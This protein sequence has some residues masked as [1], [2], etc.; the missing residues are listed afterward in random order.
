MRGPF[1]ID[2]GDGEGDVDK[3]IA[4]HLELR[5]REFMA[6][7]MTPEAARAAALEA[8]GDRPAIEAQV[9][10]IHR[11]TRSD[12]RRREWFGELR[13]D[14]RV[15]VRML[16]RSPGFAIA[17]LL[18]L[19]LGIGANTAIFSVLR[20]V[21]LR[22]LP[23]PAPAELVQVWAD[24]TA[25]GRAEPEW[26]TPPDFVDQQRDNRTFAAM[27][28]Y[29]GWGPDLTGIGDPVSLNGL[30]VSGDYFAIL[31]ATAA[32]G[33]L[34]VPGDDVPGAPPVVVLSHGLWQ[35]RFG[36]DPGVVGRTITLSGAPWTVVGV[37]SPGFRAPI[38]G[39]APELFRGLPLSAT[40]PCGRG[41]VVLRAIGRLRPG[42]TVASAQADLATIAARLARE[43]PRS[44]DKVGAWL[45]PLHEQLTG[46][47]RPALVTLA[48]AVGLVLL[49]GCVNLANLLLVRTAGRTRELGVRAALGAGR[50]RIARQLLGENG[51]LAILGG[52]LGLGLGIVTSRLLAARVPDSLRGVQDVRIDGWV[53]AFAVVLTAMS[54]LIFGL[55]P[56]LGAARS[57]LGSAARNPTLSPGRGSGAVRSA[58]VVTQLTLA[59]TLLVGAGLLLRSFL[60]MQRVDPGFRTSG[61]ALTNVF[62]PPARYQ[63][64]PEVLQGVEQLLD[65]LRAS[66][67]IRA[68]EATD[69]PVLNQGD[70][71]ITVVAEGQA[72]PP[73]GTPSIWTRSVTPGYLSAMG[74]R[75]IRGRGLEA[76]DRL[77]APLV[78]VINEEAAR[79]Y[80]PGEES[81]VGK[82]L[83]A[84]QGADADRFTVVGVVASARHAGPS[85]PYKVEMFMPLEQVP[86]R[87]VT[88]VLQ[89]AAGL[90][91]AAGAFAEALHAV[92]PLVPVSAIDPIEARLGEAVALPRLYAALVAVFAAAALLLAALGVYGVMAYTVAERQREIGVR[93]ALGAAPGGIQ[94][95]IL[96]RGGRLAAAGIVLGVAAA[97]ALGRLLS[98][99]L[100]G[101]TPFDPA[102]LIV[103]PLVLGLVTLLASWLPARQAMRLDPALVMR[104]SD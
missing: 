58:L 86:S 60:L 35:Q 19:A 91:P 10:H 55:A 29:Q 48:V 47:S 61:V 40:S 67:A 32:L 59:V 9:R 65:R 68:A 75:L 16:R 100:F 37:L 38:Q 26:L 20:S 99:L 77:G 54:A 6:Q 18:T 50:G 22:P 70:H 101:V 15:A 69:L 83:V 103:V 97:L 81:P 96:G 79:R 80:F 41:C 95:M 24:H 28:A 30:M 93:M 1:R 52:G 62:F 12:R 21:V 23:Y 7:G 49:I 13:H 27:A 44:N 36:G 43:Y 51:L 14:L 45:V 102:T 94:R 25:L 56:A 84:G 92:D 11:D 74:M 57:A 53:L 76:T 64:A 42:V 34:I 39:V 31:G 85:Q 71:D 89:P 8:F 3:E 46:Q 17:A 98:R 78:A 66:G 72:E 82:V 73:P 104:D 5:A 90:A 2:R 63:R 33:R 88:I 87:E 4:L